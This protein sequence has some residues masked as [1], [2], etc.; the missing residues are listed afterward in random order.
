M[1]SFLLSRPHGSL[2]SSRDLHVWYYLPPTRWNIA[3]RRQEV[4]RK[5]IGSCGYIVGVCGRR[6]SRAPRQLDRAVVLSFHVNFAGRKNDAGE[7]F[8]L[9]TVNRGTP[10]TSYIGNAH[11]PRQYI[12]GDTQIFQYTV[13]ISQDKTY[14]TQGFLRLLASCWPFRGFQKHQPICPSDPGLLHPV[15]AVGAH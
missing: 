9:L 13:S 10:V 14:C 8:W 4:V 5:N 1:R 7:R 2:T 6:F 11:R 12:S 3:N 15:N